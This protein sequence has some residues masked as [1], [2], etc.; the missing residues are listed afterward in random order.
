[1]H[2]K[3]AN[4]TLWNSTSSFCSLFKGFFLRLPF[5]PLSLIDVLEPGGDPGTA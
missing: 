4:E 2:E 5:S 1:M 3:S